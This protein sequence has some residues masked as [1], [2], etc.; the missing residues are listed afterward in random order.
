VK[1]QELFCV[2]CENIF[3]MTAG[4]KIRLL[5]K[6]FDIPKRCPDCRKRKHR[7]FEE[8]DEEWGK[9]KKKRNSRRERAYFREDD[10]I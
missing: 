10:D 8:E 1:D 6:G 9:N 2:Q 5:E 7:Y 4:E 3:I